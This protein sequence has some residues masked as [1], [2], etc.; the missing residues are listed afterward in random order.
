MENLFIKYCKWIS[1]EVQSYYIASLSIEG[2]I[3][4]KV[5]LENVRVYMKLGQYN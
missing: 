4:V 5:F 2:D 3:Q 1:L